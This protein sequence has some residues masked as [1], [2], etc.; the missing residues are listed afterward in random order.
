M[1]KE[2]EKAGK[3]MDDILHHYTSIEVLALILKYKN[4]RFNRLDRVDDLE[5]G[6]TVSKGIN[7][8]KYTFVSCWTESDE[9]NIPLWKLYANG[10]N[11]VKISLPRNFFEEYP[12]TKEEGIKIGI[13]VAGEPFRCLIP[14]NELFPQ[15]HMFIPPPM[16]DG[17]FYRQIVYVDDVKGKT[18]E[19]AEVNENGV[20]IGLGEVGRY[21]HKRWEFQ[22]E[23]R[24]VLTAIPKNKNMDMSHPLFSN[25]MVDSIKRNIDL[26]IDDFYLKIK[27]SALEDMEITL[28]PSASESQFLIVEALLKAYAPKARLRHSKLK[29]KVNIK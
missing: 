14:V 3:I 28:C 21:K 9:E 6:N 29:G 22:N 1:Q 10:N 17:I 11:G 7:L 25:M 26:P 24:F 18:D 5:E 15:T 20:S 23:S 13:N 19:I 16:K 4:I 8:S 12:I 2:Q 27:E